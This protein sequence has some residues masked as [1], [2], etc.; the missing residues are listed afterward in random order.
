MCYIPGTIL[1]TLQVVILLC[2]VANLW[3]RYYYLSY[4]WMSKYRHRGI[5]YIIKSLA[6]PANMWNRLDK[7]RESGFR[8]QTLHLLG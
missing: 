3:V 2:L 7:P 5:I 4:F 1:S 8:P 6:S